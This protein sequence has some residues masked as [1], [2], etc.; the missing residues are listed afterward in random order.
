MAIF[1]SD[2]FD[3]APE[4]EAASAWETAMDATTTIAINVKNRCKFMP[5]A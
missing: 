2:F 3:L 5:P 4:H 1:V